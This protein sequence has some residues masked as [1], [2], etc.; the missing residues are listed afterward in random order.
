M[1]CV[2]SLLSGSRRGSNFRYRKQR[3]ADKGY[4]GNFFMVLKLLWMAVSG[5]RHG[6]LSGCGIAG[7]FIS[8]L[9]GKMPRRNILLAHGLP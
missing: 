5:G 8:V 2:H 9:E 6:I 7:F 1:E 3:M 4:K